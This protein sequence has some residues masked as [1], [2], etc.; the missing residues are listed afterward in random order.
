MIAVDILGWLEYLCRNLECRNFQTVA[1]FKSKMENQA[2]KK[3]V[4]I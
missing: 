2:Y 4:K 1:G 3:D